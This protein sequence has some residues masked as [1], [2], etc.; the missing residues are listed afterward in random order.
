[1]PNIIS[2]IGRLVLCKGIA[3]GTTS[4]AGLLAVRQAKRP[5]STRYPFCRVASDLI[6]GHGD[7]VLPFL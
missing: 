4:S 5:R 2:H 1:M 6:G 7:K 3:G